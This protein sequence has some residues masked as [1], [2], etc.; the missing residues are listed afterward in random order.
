[1]RERLK[2]GV[3]DVTHGGRL[4]R[5]ARRGERDRVRGRARNGAGFRDWEWEDTWGWD[6]PMVA[7]TAAALGEHE[8]VVGAL[9]AESPK[10]TWLPNGHNWHG[11]IRRCTAWKWSSVNRD[12]EDRRSISRCMA[13]RWRQCLDVR[14]AGFRLRA[15]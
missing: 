5:R 9:F 15:S 12:R 1:M 7:L 6:F 3:A 2:E 8:L 13:Q 11:P 10:N 4:G 14:T